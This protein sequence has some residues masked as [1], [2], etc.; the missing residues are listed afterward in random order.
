MWNIIP[1]AANYLGAIAGLA[2]A[3][4]A[5]LAL[6]QNSPRYEIS[7]SHKSSA[8][9]VPQEWGFSSNIGPYRIGPGA[10][11]SDVHVKIWNSGN[12]SIESTIFDDNIVIGFPNARR[13]I[14]SRFVQENTGGR[15]KGISCDP[16]QCYANIGRLMRGMGVEVEVLV[17]MKGMANDMPSNFADVFGNGSTQVYVSGDKPSIIRFFDR[18]MFHRGGDRIYWLCIL[19]GVFSWMSFLAGNITGRIESKKRIREGKAPFISRR[20]SAYSNL[21]EFLRND[22]GYVMHWTLFGLATCIFATF[23]I[24]FPMAAAFEIFLAAKPPF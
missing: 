7:Y 19:L 12:Q 22:L 2:S 8:L 10:Q 16:N 11:I 9:A 15:W 14:A 21:P 17:D 13:I 5:W 23:S 1:K 20:Q 3:V 4:I 6:T 24:V 18:H